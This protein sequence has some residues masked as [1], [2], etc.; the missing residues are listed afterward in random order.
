MWNNYNKK[1]KKDTIFL[2]VKPIA[3]NIAVRKYSNGLLDQL[4]FGFGNYNKE[5]RTIR[6]SAIDSN[7]PQFIPVS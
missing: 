3:N 6:Q 5:N 7:N 2:N 4:D 1:K